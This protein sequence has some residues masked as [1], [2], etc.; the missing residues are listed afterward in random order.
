MKSIALPPTGLPV[1]TAGARVRKRL[2]TAL[3]LVPLVLPTLALA[4]SFNVGPLVVDHPYATPTPGPSR[5]GAV[6]F[7]KLHNSGPHPDRLIGASTPV[8]ATVEFHQ[9]TVSN[10]VAR[11]RIQPS[12]ELPARSEVPFRHNSSPGHHLMLRDLRAPLKVGDKLT[13]TLHFEKAGRQDVD[14]W[15]QQP[16]DA[17]QAHKH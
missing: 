5:V 6:Y 14:V 11:M 8:A 17:Q 10:G 13:L 9:S 4:H 12:I 16:R 3:W 1:H 2:C 7:R 15:V